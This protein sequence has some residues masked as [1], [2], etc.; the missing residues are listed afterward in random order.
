[1]TDTMRAF[2]IKKV[3]ETGL[4]EKPVP[5]GPEEGRDHGTAALI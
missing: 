3:G 2:V 5:T 4:V 1:M